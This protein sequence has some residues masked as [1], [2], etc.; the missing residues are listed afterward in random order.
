MMGEG[1]IQNSNKYREITFPVGDDSEVRIQW[2][3]FENQQANLNQTL[4]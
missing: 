2:E 1:L 3:I 4:N